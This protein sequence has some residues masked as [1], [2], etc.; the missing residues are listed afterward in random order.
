MWS[1]EEGRAEGEKVSI[2]ASAEEPVE[3]RREA[4][5]AFS[6]PSLHEFS[7]GYAET[8]RDPGAACVFLYGEKMD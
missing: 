8:T 1:R 4:S 2:S 7:V 3:E 5:Q 6:G